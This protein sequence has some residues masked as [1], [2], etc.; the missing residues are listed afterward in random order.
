M[1]S[2]RAARCSGPRPGPPE[3]LF[4]MPRSSASGLKRSVSTPP[5]SAE[6]LPAKSGKSSAMVPALWEERARILFALSSPSRVSLMYFSL[7]RET[8]CRALRG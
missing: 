5:G 4:R 6:V 3:S 7:L 1:A 8:Y 2:F